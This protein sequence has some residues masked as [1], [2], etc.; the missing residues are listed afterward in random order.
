MK[1]AEIIG[2]HDIIEQIKKLN[3][4]GDEL[5][6]KTKSAVVTLKLSDGTNKSIDI[7]EKLLDDLTDAVYYKIEAL[8]QVLNEKLGNTVEFSNKEKEFLN[9]MYESYYGDGE[10]WD[11]YSDT[12]KIVIKR[13]IGKINRPST[14]E[15]IPD[16]T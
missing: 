13:M 10:I 7:D 15:D 14:Y 5:G 16:I 9:E 3:K 4:L 1:I 12:E 8:E 2:F 11:N 6:N